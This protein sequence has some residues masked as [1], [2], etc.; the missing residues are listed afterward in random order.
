MARGLPRAAAESLLV[1]RFVGEAIEA[2]TH[3]GARLALIGEIEGW[4]AAR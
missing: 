2:V 1:R 4:L 3:E